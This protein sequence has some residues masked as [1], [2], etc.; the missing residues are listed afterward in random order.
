MTKR[1]RV[2]GGHG[3]GGGHI[4]Y[5]PGPE[6]TKVIFFLFPPEL[7]TANKMHFKG[8]LKSIS[9]L[10]SLTVQIVFLYCI[11]RNKNS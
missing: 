1:H 2:D 9:T 3:G 6:G 4:E 11:I 7:T 8:R 5:S 10:D